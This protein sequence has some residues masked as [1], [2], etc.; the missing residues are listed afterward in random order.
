[1]RERKT[2]TIWGNLYLFNDIWF[3]ITSWESMIGR[4]KNSD[5]MINLP[6]ISRN[7]AVLTFHDGIWS[8]TDLGSKGGIKVNGA[9]IEGRQTLNFGDTITLAGLDLLLLAAET[10]PLGKISENRRSTT[11]F[12][13][14]LILIYQ[15]LGALQ[16]VVAKGSAVMPALPASI[17]LLLLAE[18][19]HYLLL[20]CYKRNALE[21]V[22]LAYFLCGM[23]MLIVASAAPNSLYKQLTAILIGM[24][25]YTVIDFLFQKL[26][27]AVKIKYFLMSGA[28]VLLVMNLALGE[29][30]FGAKN[31]INLGF[32]TFQPMEFVKVAFVLAGTATLDRLLTTRNMAAFIAFSCACILTLVLIRDFGTA[33]VFFAA[34][35]IMAFMQSGDIRSLALLV[36]AAFFVGIGVVAFVPYVTKRFAVWRRAWQFANTS[37]Y[38]QTR[39]MIAAASGGLLGVG[40]GNGYLVNVIAA[41]TDLVFGILCEEWGLLIALVVVSIIVFLGIYPVLLAGNSRSAFYTISA[42]GAATILVVQTALNVLGSTDILPLTGVTIPFISNGGSSMITSWALLALIRSVKQ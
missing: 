32:I 6:F 26:G 37:G 28:L 13:L 42:C 5:I 35:V 27:Q 20:R 39:T 41:D 40:G 12:T 16:L 21:M 1:M 19:S 25:V 14:L 8:I 22:L 33:L 36:A 11:T 38:Q 24:T 18:C 31:W 7:H 9:E 10:E 3:P 15:L 30:Y 2:K 29:T 23:N 17:L 4:G 34:F